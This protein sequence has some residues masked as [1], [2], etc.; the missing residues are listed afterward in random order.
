MGAIAA[1]SLATAEVT[2]SNDFGDV[3]TEIIVLSKIL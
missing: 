1:A 2:I 3:S